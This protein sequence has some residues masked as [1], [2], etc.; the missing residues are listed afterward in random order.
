MHSRSAQEAEERGEFPLT[1]AVEAVYT[2]LECKKHGVSRREVRDFLERN[3]QRGWNHIAGPATFHGGR[4]CTIGVW[5]IAT[6]EELFGP[7]CGDII[8][9][10]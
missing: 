9:N 1:R 8:G 2:S 10:F 5:D 3:C 4:A 6:G 7:K